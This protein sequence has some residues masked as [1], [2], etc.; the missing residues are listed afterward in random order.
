MIR[1]T[2]CIAVMAT[3]AATA[4]PAAQERKHLQPGFSQDWQGLPSSHFDGS[5][6]PE[7]KPTRTR[8][9]RKNNYGNA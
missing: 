7:Y 9:V 3:G 8:P 2:I 5:K 1:I 6:I 4:Q